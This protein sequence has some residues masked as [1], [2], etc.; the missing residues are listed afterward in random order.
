MNTLIINLTR[1]GDLLQTQPVL[2][3]LAAKG[4]VPGLACLSHFSAAAKL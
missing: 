4:E 1:F 3:G 2:A